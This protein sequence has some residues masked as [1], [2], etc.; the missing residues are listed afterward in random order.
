[1]F[2]WIFFTGEQSANGEDGAE[3]P[4]QEDGFFN[5]VEGFPTRRPFNPNF[6]RPRPFPGDYRRPFQRGGSVDRYNKYFGP[7]PPPPIPP[8]F[9]FPPFS[10]RRPWGRGGHYIPPRGPS[11][12]ENQRWHSPD[13]AATN[14]EGQPI[15]T[16][17]IDNGN[18]FILF[19]RVNRH[20]AF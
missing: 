18:A 14:E 19:L 11:P 15:H 4:Q 13:R 1:M 17:L 16:V 2:S 3:S 10:R 7:R 12:Y 9:G 6:D 8:G 5:P 20:K